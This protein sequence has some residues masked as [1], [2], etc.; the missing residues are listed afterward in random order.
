MSKPKWVV[1]SEYTTREDNEK[2]CRD[3]GA[4]PENYDIEDFNEVE[5]SVVRE[6][7]KTG[8]ESYG[9]DGMDKIILF[10]DEVYTE[11]EINWCKKVAETVCEAL[12]RK[13]L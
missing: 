4:D 5:I 7:N 8:L 13:G 12:N 1:K 2:L 6:D 3:Q 11:K 9:W 10:E